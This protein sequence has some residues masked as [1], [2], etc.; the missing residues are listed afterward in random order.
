[1]TVHIPVLAREILEWLNPKPGQIIVDGTVGGG[2]HTRLL[3]EQVGANGL[4]VGIDRDEKAI[5]IASKSL[6]GLPVNLLAGNFSDIPEI[7]DGLEI[8]LVSSALLD[9]GLSS[10][11]LADADR[12]F[13][14]HSAGD[15]DLRF[16]IS[17][18][19]PAWRLLNRLSEKHLAD[20][21][22]QYGE[23]RHSRRVAKIFVETRRYTQL[24][25]ANEIADL[26]RKVVPR[27]KNH[28]IDSATRTF[29]AFRIA[30]NEEL[31]W[32]KVAIRR[33]AQR[34]QPGGRIAIISFHSLEDRLVKTGFRES[35]DLRLLHS[36]PIRP[37]ESE[38]VVN[39]RSRSSRLRVA[40]RC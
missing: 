40:E 28:S 14:Y 13:S 22:F 37:S 17:R 15:F 12:G 32:I 16:D 39:P 9:L 10:D 34:L 3:A 23:E 25:K 33:I 4:V 29:Q 8:G 27:S 2:G 11:Q 1:M 6:S 35:A 38:I 36:K 30:V 7:L 20:L 31:K 18:G 19:E 24:R 26:I 21:I 5:E